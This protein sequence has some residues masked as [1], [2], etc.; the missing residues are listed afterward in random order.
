MDQ[1]G[2][3]VSNENLPLLYLNTQFLS[4]VFVFLENLIDNMSFRTHI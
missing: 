4:I 2:L 3:A 1:N